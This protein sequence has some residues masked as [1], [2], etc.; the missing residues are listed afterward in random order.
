MYPL[1]CDWAF[2]IGAVVIRLFLC[3]GSLVGSSFGVGFI[4]FLFVV[5]LL[6][7]LLFL[8]LIVYHVGN[9]LHCRLQK[10]CN[11]IT[12]A[13][14]LGSSCCGSNTARLPGHKG[15]L[16][17][18][19]SLHNLL[20]PRNH[21]LMNQF[22]T[23]VMGAMPRVRQDLQI[24]V[25]MQRMPV[26]RRMMRHPRI[27]IAPQCQHGARNVGQVLFG[28]WARVAS[29]DIAK[30]VCGIVIVGGSQQYFEQFRID[31]SCITVDA[32]LV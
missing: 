6:L 22:R 2:R 31:L 27:G 17:W 16:L 7:L 12:V 18:I 9:A 13:V 25:R 20:H 23:I 11:I 10:G 24:K 3:S 21:G 5:F 19:I 30:D 29:H 32:P 26:T 4:L 14:L 28:P 15:M 8:V 1:V